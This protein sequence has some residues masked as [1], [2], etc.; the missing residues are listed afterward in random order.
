MRKMIVLVLKDHCILSAKRHYWLN[1]KPN[2]NL[3]K[4]YQV[5]ISK[6]NTEYISLNL[7]ND[8]FKDIYSEFDS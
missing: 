4:V 5:D 1:T 2:F 6:D 7:S 3:L 8:N